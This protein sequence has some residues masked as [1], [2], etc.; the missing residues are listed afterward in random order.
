[1]LVLNDLRPVSTKHK[2][3]FR[4]FYVRERLSFILRTLETLYCTLKVF[5]V[6]KLLKETKMRSAYEI[7]YATYKQGFTL[8]SIILGS[9]QI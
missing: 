9:W 7:F 2:K 5:Y 3:I 1:M 4:L 6:Q 8:S